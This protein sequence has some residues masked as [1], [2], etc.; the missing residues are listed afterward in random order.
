MALNYKIIFLLAINGYL[1]LTTHAR[2]T[3]LEEVC[4]K[5]V[6]IGFCLN[7]FGSD[8]ATRTA[9]LP[10]LGQ[11]AIA[12]ATDRA[13]TTMKKSKTRSFFASDPK[14]RDA[15]N[16]CVHEYE[17]ALAALRAA[18]DH[19][20]KGRYADVY[21]HASQAAGEAIACQQGFLDRSV[22]SPLTRE[23]LQLRDY[24]NIIEVIAD[25]SH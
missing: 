24:C 1:F 23:N 12:K 18:P 4:N 7:V 3:L 20:R 16:E 17:A 22:R 25:A 11:L 13:V 6:N 8:P 9:S 21:R 15:L 19:L 14:I 2:P 10:D 5:T